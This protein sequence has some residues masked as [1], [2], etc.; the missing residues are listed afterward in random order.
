[1]WYF[2]LE[3]QRVNLNNMVAKK[4][5][6]QAK[7]GHMSEEEEQLCGLLAQNC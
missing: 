1:M 5:R 3:D 6:E 4:V 2:I 7:V